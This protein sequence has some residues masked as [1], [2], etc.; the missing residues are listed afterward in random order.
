MKFRDDLLIY[1]TI[2]YSYEP[3]QKTKDIFLKCSLFMS[4][5]IM[6]YIYRKEI[7]TNF[8]TS[9]SQFLTVL[10]ATTYRCFRR[11]AYL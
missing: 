1:I 10:F 9:H 11:E 5:S 3:F 7:E 8:K 6:P 2:E 4:I